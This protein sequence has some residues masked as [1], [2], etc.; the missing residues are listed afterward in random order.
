MTVTGE[1]DRSVLTACYELG[2][3]LQLPALTLKVDRETTTLKPWQI[4]SWMT[5]LWVH[6]AEFADDEER[7]LRAVAEHR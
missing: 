1:V 2:A 6:N 3:S 5:N 4:G 7:A